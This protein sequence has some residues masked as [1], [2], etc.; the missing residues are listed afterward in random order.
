VN[1]IGGLP[2]SKYDVK[3]WDIQPSGNS[4]LIYLSGVLYVSG[5]NNP[6]NFV[7]NFILSPTQNGSFYGK[8]YKIIINS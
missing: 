8:K 3:N 5:E 1:K 7:R 2:I 6:I 4:I